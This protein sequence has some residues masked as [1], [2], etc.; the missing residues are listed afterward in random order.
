MIGNLSH[1]LNGVTASSSTQGGSK[2]S[3]GHRTT[4]NSGSYHYERLNK[5]HSTGRVAMS[6]AAGPTAVAVEHSSRH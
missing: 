3:G 2:S 1:M 5:N 6:S 4:T